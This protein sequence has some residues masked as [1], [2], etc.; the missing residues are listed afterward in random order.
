MLNAPGPGAVEVTRG[1][2]AL[3]QL[4]GVRASR[5]EGEVALFDVAPEGYED[6]ANGTLPGLRRSG[7]VGNVLVEARLGSTIRRTE[8]DEKGY[9]AFDRLLP[10][11]WTVTIDDHSLPERHRLER[12]EFVV[13]LAAGSVEHL[14]ARA[15]P[16]VHP[17]KIIGGGSLSI[18][19]ASSP[20]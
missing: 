17:I 5:I 12:K 11:E 1:Q 13:Q 10:G 3:R 9:F 7:A 20:P 8:S 6:L 19:S 4:E 15:L 16:I 18:V 14:E 2:R